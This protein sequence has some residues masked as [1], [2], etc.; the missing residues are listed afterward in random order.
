MTFLIYKDLFFHVLPLYIYDIMTTENFD[1]MTSSALLNVDETLTAGTEEQERENPYKLT[2]ALLD[3]GFMFDFNGVYVP[4]KERFQLAGVDG[5]M[6]TKDNIYLLIARNPDKKLE[7]NC[8]WKQKTPDGFT[9]GRAFDIDF[10][11]NTGDEKNIKTLNRRVSY[12]GGKNRNPASEG[13]YVEFVE[14]FTDLI[15][16]SPCLEVFK[17]K[18]YVFPEI[19]EDNDEDVETKPKHP[20]SFSEYNEKVQHEALDILE[21]GSLFK[22][23]QKCVSIT[24]EGHEATRD[25]LILM[26]NSIF[27]DDGAHGCLGGVS[28]GGKTD[29]ALACAM[30]IPAKHVHI[31]SSSTPK[32]IFYDFESYDEDFNILI[33]DDV[34]MTEELIKLIKL[35]T[36]NKVKK[37][38]HKTV[39]NGKAEK[40]ELKGKYEIIIT[41]AKTI[42]DEELANRLFNIGVT[43]IDKTEDKRRVKRRIRDNN[44]I[45]SDENMLI[46]DIRE[47]IRA[48]VQYLIEQQASVYNP[49]LSIF[50]PININNRDI[51]HLTSMTNTR[52]F[53]DLNKR[54]QIK[55]NDETVLT[56]GSLDDLS[57]VYNI[58]ARDEEAQMYKLS[59][60][61][62]RCLDILPEMT[63]KEAFDHVEDLNNQLKQADSR[64]YKKKLQDEE[65]FRK[66]LAKK[67]HVNPSTLKH[68]LDRF[69]EG[70]QKSLCEIGLVD[71]IQLDEDNDK[72]PLFYYKVKKDGATPK[73]Q[74]NDVQDVQIEFA[75]SFNSSIVKQK[76]IIDLLI[77]ANVVLSK[78]GWRVFENYC[79]DKH[80]ELNANSYD[81]M[82]NFLKC[83]FDTLDHEK[84]FIKY[85]ES[86][87]DDKFAMLK[88]KAKLVK[89]LENNT[90]LDTLADKENICTYKE[91]NET[92]QNTKQDSN[93]I[94]NEN[95][96][97]LHIFKSEIKEFLEEKNIDVEIACDTYEFLIRN[98]E[99]TLQ[100]ITNYICETVNPDDFNNETTPLKI[101]NNLNRMFV[102]DLLDFN[103]NSYELTDQFMQVVTSASNNQKGVKEYVEK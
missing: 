60:L 71:K 27:V 55:V 16:E 52:T 25:A 10:L 11:L 31:I 74:I 7:I 33:F 83:F 59:E 70:N 56:I 64:A 68:A 87:R 18:E 53:F 69:N 101:D 22:E 43:I 94:A 92:A 2:Q 19:I 76:I 90:P 88:N 80:V 98:D 24:H 96:S 13:T 6:E 61:Q 12:A 51:N 32:D 29:L 17:Q 30:H 20:Q 35:L 1:E 77:C 39:I 50:D 47:P 91:N 84:D 34:L 37:K 46:N 28:G 26:E 66:Q 4:F 81:D 9:N 57:F 63:D 78:R 79:E 49:Y 65:P 14:Y 82:I 67:L 62:K 5:N 42:P 102:H 15:S 23:T 89:S 97:L 41:Y 75:H 45:K 8:E 85:E 38:V 3:D 86:S 100:D 99:G 93:K 44:I 72:S 36:D 103:R 48:G 73:H 95:C 58:W 54:E 21:N 40:F